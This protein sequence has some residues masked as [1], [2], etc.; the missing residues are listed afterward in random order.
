MTRLRILL[1]DDQPDQVEKAHLALIDMGH[2]VVVVNTFLNAEN[3]AESQAFDIAVIDLGWGFDRSYPGTKAEA[4]GA[5]WKI[6][7]LVT[8]QPAIVPILEI[9]KVSLI[10]AVPVTSSLISG[11]SIPSMASFRS[12]IAS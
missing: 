8:I 7:P 11:E 6:F 10:S 5:G 3:I 12:L 4:R 9:L 2:E 1:A